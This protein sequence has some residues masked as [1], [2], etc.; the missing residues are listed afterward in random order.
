MILFPAIDLYEGRAVRLL[1]GD[2][3]QMTVYSDNPVEIARDF[4]SCG[5]E[6]VHVVDL[7]GARDS[8]TPNLELIARIARET[9]LKVEVGG[10]IRSMDTA[11]RYLTSGVS[12]IVLGTAAVKDPDFLRAAL[13]EF[14]DSVAV[15]VDVNGDN[16]AI[17]GWTDTSSLNCFDF[18]RDM[19]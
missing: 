17:H 6:W 12:R 16:V 4:E 8:T 3:A 15:G 13:M 18:C 5:A 7:E 11:R 10:G 2:Y 9:A 14:G 19:A 1:K